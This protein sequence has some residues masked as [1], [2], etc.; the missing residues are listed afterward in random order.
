MK[1]INAENSILGRLASE[2]AKLAMNGEEIII[3]NAE[4]AVITGNADD[5]Y[6]RYYQRFKIRDI[7]KPEKSPKMQ[8]RP[9]LFVKRT[10]RGMIPRRKRSGKEA[11]SRVKALIGTPKEYEGKGEF[12]ESIL[13]KN[14]KKGITVE[15]LCKKLGWKG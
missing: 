12:I 14:N 6:K 3:T 9:D 11:L 15:K 7:A 2:V 8:R 13:N 5:I 10:I 1:I 4:K